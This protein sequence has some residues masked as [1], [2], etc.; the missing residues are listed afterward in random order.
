[1]PDSFIRTCTDQYLPDDD[2][3]LHPELLGAKAA[4]EKSKIW[5]CDTLRISFT[6]QLGR[7]WSKVG[8]DA[9]AQPTHKP[10]MNLGWLLPTFYPK[11]TDVELRHVV[12]HE[13]GHV[14]GHA[15]ADPKGMDHGR[16]GVS[17][18]L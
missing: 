7:S 3:F 11:T 16:L 9:L 6:Y 14:L 18:K 10:T 4:A 17:R 8:K 12:L 15:H 1:M 2:P 5:D 13:F